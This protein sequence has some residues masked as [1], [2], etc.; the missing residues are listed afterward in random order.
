MRKRV[1]LTL[2]L[3]AALV[4]TT[5]CS[6]IVKDE[7]VDR[8]TTIIEVAGR[9]IT[10]AEVNEQVEA[11]LDYQEYMYYLYGLSFDR[12]SETNISDARDS[13]IEGLIQEAVL[14]QKTAELGLDELSDEDLAEVQENTETTWQSYKDSIQSVYFSESELTDAELDE[15]VEAKMAELGYPTKEELEESERVTKI[16]ENLRAEVVKDV[17]VSE[18]EIAAEY[19]DRKGEAMTTYGNTPSTYGTDVTNG[20]TIYY[21][22]AGYR[23]V[24]NILI[25]LKEE[26]STAISDIQSQITSKQTELSS[27]ETSLTELGEDASADDEETA[28][29]RAEL[30]ATK[31][32]LTAELDDLNA[33][34]DAA[35]EA[36]YEA[37]QPTADEVLAKLAEGEDFDAL[38]EEYGEDTGMQ[39]SPAKENGYPV[40]AESTNWV[41][42]FR[43]AAMALENIGDV[44][45]AVRTTYGL[46]IIQ[47]VSDAEEGAVA[48]EDVRDVIESEL[49]SEKQSE[50]YNATVEQWVTDADAKTYKDRL[51]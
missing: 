23:Y 21:V 17:T 12:T 42:E 13:A 30:T 8:Q 49:L 5:S 18:D 32:Q 28:A 6:L 20:N 25:K 51:D 38:M 19:E 39:V 33:Q 45:E 15:A 1:I 26:D 41:T 24:K 44:S 31:D 22:P 11:V 9:T 34:L 27:A 50:T 29:T 37:I 4:V 48:L 16:R 36:A 3:A 46:H 14:D 47:Y 10:K 43:D 40:C 35:K 7:E 2:M